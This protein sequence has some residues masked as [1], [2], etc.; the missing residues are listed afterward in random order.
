MRT[1]VYRLKRVQ[2]GLYF[3]Q[4][5]TK[6]WGEKGDAR[7]FTNL[8]DAR[9]VAKKLKNRCTTIEIEIGEPEWI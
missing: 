4:A 9:R 5:Y 3:G 7:E 6:R 8:S 1:R 2:S